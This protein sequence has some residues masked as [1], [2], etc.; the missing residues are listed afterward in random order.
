VKWSDTEQKWMI[1]YDDG[2]IQFHTFKREKWRM[3]SNKKRVLISSIRANQ[4]I[5]S[6]NSNSRDNFRPIVFM[7]NTGSRN[8][9]CA[10]DSLLIATYS[11]LLDLNY[12]FEKEPIDSV[13]YTGDPFAD[14][15]SMIKIIHSKKSFDSKN[16]QLLNKTRDEWRA[17]YCEKYLP[18]G[19]GNNFCTL[20]NFLSLWL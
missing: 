20:E 9:S 17:M 3:I 5:P 16:R 6:N 13:S 18:N 12:D 11:C 7:K 15:L 2:D 8:Y 1:K 4:N 19:E 10:P 14:F